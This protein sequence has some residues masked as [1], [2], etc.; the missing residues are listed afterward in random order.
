MRESNQGLIPVAPVRPV[1]AYLGGKRSLAKTVIA[2]IQNVPHVAYIEPFSGMGGIFLRRPFQA[3]CEVINDLNGDIAN[4]FRILQRHYVPLMDMLRWQ[5][6]S[7]E[8][9]ERLRSAERDTLTDLERA[10]RF[11]YLQRTAFGG[12]PK[13]T[14]FGVTASASARFDVAKLGPILEDVHAR[15]SR[16]VIECL[17]WQDIIKRYDKP[18]TLFYLDP[19]YWG[20]ETDYRAPFSRD[21]FEQM[22][23][24]LASIQGRFILSL[25]DRPEVRETFKS[26]EIESVLAHYSINPSSQGKRGEVLISN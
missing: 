5:V 10:V 12:N 2:R 25:N 6:T 24:V 15:L 19:P 3:K 9:F 8:H 23:D 7:R 17:P 1:A 21:Q 13:W 11:L 18:G 22:A 14:A 16:V 4:L 26:F 20:N